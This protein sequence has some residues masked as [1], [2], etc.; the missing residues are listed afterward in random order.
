MNRKIV[1]FFITIL[2][3]AN[4][5]PVI[6]KMNLTIDRKS[7]TLNLQQISGIEFFQVDYDWE[8]SK[9]PNSNTGE[10]VVDIDKVKK[11]TGLKSGYINA[12]SE[13]G[14]IIQNLIYFENSPYPYISRLFN[15]G[16]TGDVKNINIH[17]AVSAEPVSVFEY[18]GAL[19][20][21]PVL[22]TIY[23]AEGC[24][25]SI[26]ILRPQPPP[27]NV[28]GASDFADSSETFFYRQWEHPNVPCG[29]NQCSPAAYANNLQ[30]LENVFGT[31]VD[32]DLIWGFNGSPS[33]SLP[34]VLDI[35]M[36]RNAENM[37]DGDCTGYRNGLN[38][39]VNYTFFED[40]PIS[41][42]HQGINGNEDISFQGVTS[43]GQGTSISTDFIIN[44]IKEGHAVALAWASFGQAGKQ[45]GAHMV[46]LVAAG[47]ILGVPF[48]QYLDDKS[49]GDY[50]SSYTTTQTFIRDWDW[51][52]KPNLINLYWK[53]SEPPEITQLV[54][55][56]AEN[57]PPFKP[58]RPAGGEFIMKKGVEYEFSTITTDP[59]GDLLWWD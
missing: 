21:Y 7:N 32:H 57:R 30:Y 58:S 23:D 40:L 10:I 2:L 13:Q 47:K 20:P 49:Q 18:S 29:K 43:Y 50:S 59:D 5:L 36:D 15:L 27:A 11:A 44:E 54:V 28:P 3:I 14:W 31:P 8:K 46:Q 24:N 19:P 16:R 55:M 52:G 26:D 37:T 12:Y 35:Y 34:A 6:G 33:N 45:T 42:K 38:G 17:I 9:Y 39:F 4:A 53:I 41:I 25:E 22:D 51:D 1:G 56:T 48:I